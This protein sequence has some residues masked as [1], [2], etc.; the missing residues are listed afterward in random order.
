MLKYLSIKDE[1]EFN[2]LDYFEQDYIEDFKYLKMEHGEDFYEPFDDEIEEF[3]KSEYIRNFISHSYTHFISVGKSGEF[4]NKY[5]PNEVSDILQE[6]LR[7]NTS[8][9]GKKR[10]IFQFPK[11]PNSIMIK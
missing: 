5:N 8:E 7:L 2:I 9:N 4:S 10:S 11:I 3:D 6:N 1:E